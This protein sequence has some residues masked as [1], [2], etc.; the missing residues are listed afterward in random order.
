MP[1]VDFP[2]SYKAWNSFSCKLKKFAKHIC[3]SSLLSYW[4]IHISKTFKEITKGGRIGIRKPTN[5][6]KVVK[7]V[8]SDSEVYCHFVV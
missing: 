4:S 3:R 5:G 8:K 1:K 2:L 6:D 7:V